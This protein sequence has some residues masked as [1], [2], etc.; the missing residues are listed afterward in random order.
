MQSLRVTAGLLLL[1]TSVATCAPRSLAG[2]SVAPPSYF[3]GASAPPTALPLPAFAVQTL[4]QGATARWG[5]G[6]QAVA[7]VA[8]GC[9]VALV[10]LARNVITARI[11]ACSV[12]PSPTDDVFLARMRDGTLGAWDRQG[13][14]RALLAADDHGSEAPVWSP[15]GRRVAI[16]FPLGIVIRSADDWSEVQ[17]LTLDGDSGPLRW[18]GID[19]TFRADGSKLVVADARRL[20]LADLDAAG[21]VSPF[22]TGCLQVRQAS[23]APRGDSLA[24]ECSGDHDAEIWDTRTPRIVATVPH[25]TA[26]DRTGSRVVGRD[27]SH[28]DVHDAS[29][30]RRLLRVDAH[31]W[32]G[33]ALSPDG[34][35]IAVES[36]DG[37]KRALVVWDVATAREVT[38]NADRVAPAWSADGRFLTETGASSSDTDRVVLETSTWHEVWRRGQGSSP[39]WSPSGARLAV[40]SSAASLRLD[41]LATG[42]TH[43]LDAAFSVPF[44]QTMTD[45]TGNLVVQVAAAGTC[46][47]LHLDAREGLAIQVVAC[48][49]VEASVSP[50][51]VKRTQLTRSSPSILSPGFWTLYV[52]DPSTGE[53]AFVD[54][55]GM[56]NPQI[57]WS[58]QGHRLL[59]VQG[60]ALLFE[61]DRQ[62]AWAV[63]VK[64][65]VRAATLD[66]DGSRAALAMMDGSV[67]VVRPTSHEP[68]LV[69]AGPGEQVEPPRLLA[70]DGDRVAGITAHGDVSVWD[71]TGRT[72]LQRWSAGFDPEHVALAADGQVLAIS[73]GDTLQL[74]RIDGSGALT[75]TPLSTGASVTFFVHDVTGRVDGP[76]EALAL[77]RWPVP[78]EG[79]GPRWMDAASLER[80]TGTSPLQRGMLAQLAADRG[81]AD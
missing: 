58:R 49:D 40:T 66:E 62:R 67:L 12:W 24:L 17:H 64:G 16:L 15:D 30:G 70:F 18:T 13:T 21:S 52:D 45:A 53:H 34:E 2:R 68:P 59:V 39:E 3:G 74:S 60:Q 65:L 51:G 73:R 43:T 14:R 7:L 47:A 33:Y 36:A 31:S 32:D 46:S 79:G 78:T 76:A 56:A 75:V 4:P 42:A 25:F 8:P 35:R 37:G 26:W 29:T 23:F 72:P 50:D 80:E 1:S 55:G 20:L 5:G 9:D 11:P 77:L 71:V 57:V 48:A 6:G 63:R 41:D 61:V 81:H 22:P 69:L 10:D 44:T 54:H 28:L 38:R 19:G 27:G